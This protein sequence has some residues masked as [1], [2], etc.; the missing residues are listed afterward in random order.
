MP[1]IIFAAFCKWGS[2]FTRLMKLN[3]NIKIFINFILGPILFIWLSWS[4]Y[5]QV[6]HQ[7]NLEASWL[8]IKESFKSPLIINLFVVIFLM[9]VN[10]SLE[11]LKWRISVQ[12]VQQVSFLKSLMAI[13]SGVSFAV[14][15]PNRTGE[16]LGRVLYMNEGN[17]LKVI[18]LTI[19]GSIS[20]LIATFLFG[21][22]GIFILKSRIIE[23]GSSE[24]PTWI[25]L[26][27]TGGIIALF[28]LTVF[29]F[30]LN[31]LAK[32]I[33]KLPGIKKYA[34]LISELE[35]VNATLLL[36]LLSLSLV[37]YIIFGI[38][39]Y[40]LFQFFAIDVNAWQGFWAMAIVFFIMAVIPT[41]ALFEIVQKVYVAKEIFAIFTVNTLGIGLV[42]T[43]IWC[44]N[45]VIPAIIGSLLIISIKIFKK[46][47]ENS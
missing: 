47:N 24:W 25:N 31:W 34:W 30:K 38:Q 15:T 44:I 45:L 28:F 42:T 37:R 6:N 46:Q 36:Q 19:L 27:L 35:K 11:A 2:I 14:T 43:T 18:S 9:L 23:S 20:Q 32:W 21:V 7:P 4:I 40:L 10:W 33:D 13:F 1:S 5:N 22:A 39:Y 26:V 29:Y 12:Q 16:Y 8:K 17:R 3:K 41:I